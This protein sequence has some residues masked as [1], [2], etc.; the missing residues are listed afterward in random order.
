MAHL[1][2]G[3]LLDVEVPVINEK[4]LVPDEEGEEK[5]KTGQKAQAKDHAVLPEGRLSVEIHAAQLLL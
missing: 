2:E 4:A 5:E 1:V 3:N